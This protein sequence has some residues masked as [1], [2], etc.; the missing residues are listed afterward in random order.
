MPPRLR[1]RTIGPE[2]CRLLQGAPEV[3]GDGDVCVWLAEPGAWRA[4]EDRERLL[5][6]LSQDERDR[7]HRLRF[8]A[9]RA[10]FL[11]AHG[12]LRIALSRYAPVSPQQWTFRADPYGLPSIATPASTLCFSLSHTR[13]LVACALVHGR[14]V[15]VD[16]EDASRAAPLEVAERYFAAAEL[17]D[18]RTA[19]PGERARRFFEYWT[20]KE[21]YAKARGLG[22]A[23][24]F[25][26]FEFRREARGTWRIG[27]APTPLDDPSDWWFQTWSTPTHQGAVALRMG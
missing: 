3:L 13:G 26:R 22:L 2:E 14:S 27:F 5:A 9:D 11:V 23:L 19:P 4:P 10:A 20:L 16:V 6:L 15:G 8:D 25:D 24:P 12:L 1:Q 21:A 17:G 18:L 7:L